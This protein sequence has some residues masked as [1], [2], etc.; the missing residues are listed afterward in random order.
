M[1]GHDLDGNWLVLFFF[2]FGPNYLRINGQKFNCATYG[3]E[4]GEG[5]RYR[6]ANQ[7]NQVSDLSFSAS[8]LSIRQRGAGGLPRR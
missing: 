3:H 1:E 4:R 7:I 2:S 5:S 8:S 6:R